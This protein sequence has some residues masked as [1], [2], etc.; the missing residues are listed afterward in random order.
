MVRR[1]LQSLY[2]LA[3]LFTAWMTLFIPSITPLFILERNQFKIS[4]KRLILNYKLETFVILAYITISMGD[5]FLHCI[6]DSFSDPLSGMVAQE[7]HD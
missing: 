2:P 4:E 3:R 1:F 5:R 7:R 6:I